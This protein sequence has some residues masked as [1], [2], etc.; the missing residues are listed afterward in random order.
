MVVFFLKNKPPRFSSLVGKEQFPDSNNPLVLK[1]N[2]V[3]KW[4]FGISW[5]I[6][7]VEL[8]CRDPYLLNIGYAPF[9]PMAS[10]TVASADDGV[11]ES[12]KDL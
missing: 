5:I 3:T 1:V 6:M 2:S 11:K 7:I 10:V 12:T 4:L 9:I 8:H